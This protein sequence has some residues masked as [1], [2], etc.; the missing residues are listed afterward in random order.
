MK[1]VLAN[2]ILDFSG[3]DDFIKLCK[4]KT[5]LYRDVEKLIESPA[6]KNTI[7]LIGHNLGISDKNKWIETFCA[8]LDCRGI[9]IK[10]ELSDLQLIW[11]KH[12][13][14]ARSRIEDIYILK[15]RIESVVNN[16]KFIEIAEKY[17]PMGIALNNLKVT[18]L[19]F[20]PNALGTEGIIM[21]ALFMDGYSEDEIT[22]IL[23]HELHHIFRAKVESNYTWKEEHGDIDQALYWFESEGIA[24]L[25]NFKE[26]SKIY[27]KYGYAKKGELENTLKNMKSHINIID[28][29]MLLSIS[30]KNNSRELLDY[31]FDNVKFHSIGFFM[32]KTIEE[33]LG[34]EVI[35]AV[36]GDPIAFINMYQKACKLDADRNEYAFSYNLIDAIN[37]KVIY[38]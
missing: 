14:E 27:E 34:V 23:A 22:K 25:C 5:I 10:E 32:A 1:G 28:R 29:I 18:T 7:K 19:I 12:I 6:Y 21:D 36:V 9:S 37:N 11:A 13:K 26:T 8:G 15:T 16:R 31:L 4:N 24:D 3:C 35:R 17:I 33:V 2:I 30:K 38:K 20:A